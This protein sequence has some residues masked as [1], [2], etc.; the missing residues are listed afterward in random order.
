MAD[1]RDELSIKKRKAMESDNEQIYDVFLSHSDID[2]DFVEQIGCKLEREAGIRVWLDKWVLVPGE[3]WQREIEKGLIKAKTCAIFIGNKEPQGWF[4]E[5]IE[6]A[7]N[8]QVEDHTF[9]VIP[10]IIPGG[11]REFIGDF[12]RNRTWVEFKKGI[13]DEDAF[14]RIVS[15]IK[16]KPPGMPPYKKNNSSIESALSELKIIQVLKPYLENQVVLHYQKEIVD[17]V[18]KY[19]GNK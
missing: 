1:S 5:E 6:L 3:Q 2:S 18:I 7:Q 17:S 4:L 16:G 9:R 19:K 11:S 14:D 12:L 13:N 15:G 8:R 10:V